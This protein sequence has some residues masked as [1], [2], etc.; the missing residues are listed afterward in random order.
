MSQNIFSSFMPEPPT[1]STF[2]L[3]APE[4]RRATPLKEE[5]KANASSF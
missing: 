1:S 5:K 2:A 4:I 3:N